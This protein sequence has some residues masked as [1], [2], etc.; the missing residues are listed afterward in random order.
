MENK[1]PTFTFCITSKDNLRYLKHAIKYIRKNCYNKEHRVLVFIDSD[2]DKTEEWCISN[3]ID[4]IK[5]PEEE[6]YGIG[7]A[8]NLL[9]EKA[10]TDFVIIYHADMIAAKNLDVNLYKHWK[11]GYII[12]ATRVEPPL[13]PED[14]SK[15][16]KDFGLWP[17]KNIS[18]GFQEEAF[19]S[20]I[21][22]KLQEFEGKTTRGVFAPW[23]VR[24]KD[25]EAVGGHD[26]I[27]KSHSEDRDLFNRFYLK[28]YTLLQSWDAI[29]YHLTCRGGQFEHATET[30]DLTRKSQDWN[31]LAHNQTREF[32]RKWGSPPVYDAYQHPIVPPK[33]DIGIS[34]KNCTAQLLQLLEPWCDTIYIDEGNTPVLLKN[35]IEK[36]QPNTAIDLNARVKP[37]EAE[38]ADEILVDINGNNFQQSDF[39]LLQQL[40]QIIKDNGEVGEF[41]LGN[42]QIKIIEMNEYQDTLI[43]I[44]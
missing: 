21:E 22:K 18:E 42:L 16:V 24:K 31:K 14:P 35:Y 1:V 5:N 29:V 32:I 34:V 36:E 19:I 20:F 4:Y 8:Y 15:V 6:L 3:K 38:R 40:P 10:Q 7:R 27:M 9:V 11:E 13:H 28:K 33:Y 30:E 25:F 23:L 26:S 12:S 44:Y 37:F 17:E 2:K 43:N 41:E 39:Q